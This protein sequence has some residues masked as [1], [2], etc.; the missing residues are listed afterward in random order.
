MEGLTGAAAILT[1]AAITPG[2]NNL[3]VMRA[4][5][6]VGI[7][8]AVPAMIGVLL[9]GLTLL[10]IVSVGAGTLFAIAPGLKTI[11]AIG[12][13]LYLA[14]LGVALV[15]GSTNREADFARPEALPGG[16]TGLFGFQLINPKGWVLVLTVVSATY[17]QD[18][19]ALILMQLAGLFA[20][21]I[22]ICLLLWS[23]LGSMM[24]RYMEGRRVR[25]WMDRV[26]GVLLIASSLLLF[27]D[28][29]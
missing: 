23:T 9:G 18:G 12:G 2:P 24:R 5:A 6:R 11:I 1:A 25:L 14:G 27:R 8:G 29:S 3:I 22:A 10:A 19:R 28:V 26:M 20:L 17:E 15:M 21:I 16:V 13:G 7:L 4:A